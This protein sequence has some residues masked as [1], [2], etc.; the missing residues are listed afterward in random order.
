MT[1]IRTPTFYTV[2]LIDETTEHFECSV[3]IVDGVLCLYGEVGDEDDVLICAYAQ[4]QW[5]WVY[6]DNE[7]GL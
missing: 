3:R 7:H 6:I 2:G 1:D 4:G 5:L